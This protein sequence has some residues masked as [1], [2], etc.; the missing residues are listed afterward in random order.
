VHKRAIGLDF[1]EASDVA[2]PDLGFEVKFYIGEDSIGYCTGA[3]G[4][5]DY[6]GPNIHLDVMPV[7]LS[8]PLHQ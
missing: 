5:E 2:E 6:M 8:Q 3:F 7:Q 1:S 4:G